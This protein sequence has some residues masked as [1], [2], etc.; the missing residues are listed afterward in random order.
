LIMLYLCT[1]GNAIAHRDYTSAASVQVMLFADRLEVWNPGTLTSALT[2]Q[3]LRE[4]HGSYPGNP[5]IAEPLYLTKYIERMGTGI[6]DMIE[7]CREAGLAEPEF[8][9]T[10][11]F[12]TVIRRKAGKAFEAVGGKVTPEVGT[13]LALSRHQVQILHNCLEERAIGD[14]MEIKG[15]SDRTKFRNQ[16]LRPLLDAGLIEMTIPDKPTSSKQKYRLTE[17]GKQVLNQDD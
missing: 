7:R 12:V 13:K 15:R 11:G 14:L 9:L 16:V 2:L 3:T 10:D 1:I 17:T 5:L 4:P 6:H 8:K